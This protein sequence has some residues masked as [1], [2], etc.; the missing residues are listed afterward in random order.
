M[1]TLLTLNPF[2]KLTMVLQGF[3]SRVLGWSPSAK[4][5]KLDSAKLKSSSQKPKTNG[6]H[7]KSVHGRL[8]VAFSPLYLLQRFVPLGTWGFFHPLI[9]PSYICLSPSICS[10]E[11][12]SIPVPHILR[13]R[14]NN[15]IPTRKRP[16]FILGLSLFHS[17]ETN[18]Y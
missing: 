11:I 4:W 5:K 14:P 8:T 18:D 17:L 15:R 12:Y 1:S 16:R 7:N 9:R 10:K 13:W 6:T 2:S 3:Q